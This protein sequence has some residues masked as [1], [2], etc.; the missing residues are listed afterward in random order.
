MAEAL[1]AADLRAALA[2]TV[3]GDP[4]GDDP[5][6]IRLGMRLGWAR[7]VIGAVAEAAGWAAGAVALLLARELL[8]AGRPAS[9]LSHAPAAIGADWT[10]AT[11]I[12]ALRA[13][14]PQDAAWA[15]EGLEEPGELWRAEAAWWRLVEAE[16]EHLAQAHMGRPAV[17]G[18]V[19]LLGVD[20][21][22]TAAALEVAARGG[23]PG[24][25]EVFDEVA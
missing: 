23:E 20:G 5:A 2:A 3:W 6:A 8:L 13:A 12:A 21:R 1:S 9:A 24:A 11:S 7:R 10:G 18:A 14:L 25:L 16:A 4:G 22:R 19:T 17:I 15:L